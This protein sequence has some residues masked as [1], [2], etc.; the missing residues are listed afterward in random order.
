LEP[1]EGLEPLPV[2]WLELLPVAWLERVLARKGL[3]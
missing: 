2:A 1:E 3:R